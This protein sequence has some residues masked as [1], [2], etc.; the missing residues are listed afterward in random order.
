MKFKPAPAPALRDVR[1]SPRRR[2]WRTP[3]LVRSESVTPA[4]FGVD[5]QKC[6]LSCFTVV[7][8]MDGVLLFV[9]YII[10]SFAVANEEEFHDLSWRKTGE[11]GG[12]GKCWWL[13][14]VSSA[15]LALM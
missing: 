15:T 5:C 13:L 9:S 11:G 8:G 7:E 2:V 14:E 3:W 1:Y 6:F 4:L 10:D 12:H